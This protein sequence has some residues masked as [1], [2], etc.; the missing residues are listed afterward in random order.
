VLASG[1]GI[2][3]GETLTAAH[4]LDLAPTILSMVGAPVPAY[5]EGKPLFAFDA[6]AG[7]A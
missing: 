7:R 1:P 5:M 3:V 4:A 2:P 6:V